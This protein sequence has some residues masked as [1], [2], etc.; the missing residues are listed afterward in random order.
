[1][2]VFPLLFVAVT[3]Q[4]VLLIWGSA[5]RELF[6]HFAPE[7]AQ[8]TIAWEKR[9]R[10]RKTRELENVKTMII[11]CHLTDLKQTRV[12]DEHVQHVDRLMPWN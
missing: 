2:S 5:K 9:R 10:R 12:M 3:S 1:M 4:N 11:T 7:E 8:R 6:S